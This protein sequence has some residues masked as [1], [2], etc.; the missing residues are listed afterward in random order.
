[1]QPLR[2][3]GGLH[4]CNPCN[5]CN[6][7]AAAA[8]NPCNPCAAEEP[9]Q[10]VR[11]GGLQSVQPVCGKEPVQPVRGGGLQSV[12]SLRSEE[13]V[14]RGGAIKV[15]ALTR[16]GRGFG[17]TD[18]RESAAAYDC[19]MNEMQ[20]AYAKSGDPIAKAYQGWRRYSTTAYQSE[21][22]GGRFVQNYASDEARPTGHL[23]TLANAGRRPVGERQLHGE[24]EGPGWRR[25]LVHHAEDAGG[26]QR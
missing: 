12:Q 11:G 1:M 15:R 25:P 23:R 16:R 14:R 24:C 9:V 19:I 10:P 21:T 13:P 17:G 7:C 8:C 3:G 4:L 5:P 18:R 2:G 22:H 26:L 6:P 20:A